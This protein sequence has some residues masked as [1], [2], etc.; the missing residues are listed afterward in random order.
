MTKPVSY[1]INAVGRKKRKQER[2]EEVEKEGTKATKI[3]QRGRNSVE[4]KEGRKEQMAEEEDRLIASNLR[5]E[6][7][8][9][10]SEC[11][12]RTHWILQIH[13]ELIFPHSSKLFR[14]EKEEYDE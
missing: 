11:L 10:Q 8:Q 1:S 3:T 2:R 6:G 13:R 12:E 14:K 4:R 5:I 9:S 7:T